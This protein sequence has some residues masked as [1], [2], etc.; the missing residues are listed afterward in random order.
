MSQIDAIDERILT[1]L[2]AN[3]RLTMKALAERVGLSSPAM[4][5]RVRRLEERGIIAGYRAVVK[6]A[7]LGRPLSAVI[8]AD[9]PAAASGAFL[10][11]LEQE[12]GIVECHRLS[13]NP[14]YV[15]RAHVADPAD[16]AELLDRLG[17][18]GANC[19]ASVILQSPLE[20]RSIGGGE[21][22]GGG[23]GRVR[24]RRR[25]AETEG[26]DDNGARRPGRPRRRVVDVA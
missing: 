17:A 25:T 19:Q 13:G 20:W 14:N 2:Q 1:E 10:E 15:A 12:S 18:S 16:L 6:P 23:S 3:G 22:H 26:G 9:V 5:E 4:I 8:L 21:E 11:A 24:R 7:T